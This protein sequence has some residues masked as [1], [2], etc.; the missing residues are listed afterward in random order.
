[1]SSR[2]KNLTLIRT[3]RVSSI[4]IEHNK[5]NISRDFNSNSSTS[6]SEDPLQ[7]SGSAKSLVSGRFLGLMWL[8]INLQTFQK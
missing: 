4:D 7:S 2:L 1:M 6:A 8:I 3:M 5:K